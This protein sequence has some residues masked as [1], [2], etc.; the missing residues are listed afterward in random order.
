MCEA[1]AYLVKDGREQLLMESVD[2]VKPE[3][4]G[5]WQLVGIF[6]DQKSVKGRIKEMNLVNHKILFEP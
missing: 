6:G 2:L 4:D 1:N 5:T 3:E